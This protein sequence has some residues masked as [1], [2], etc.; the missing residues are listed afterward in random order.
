MPSGDERLPDLTGRVIGILD[1]ASGLAHMATETL[2]GCGAYAVPLR[3]AR[4][5]ESAIR[6]LSVDALI[7]QGDHP[8]CEHIVT[9][10]AQHRI[11]AVVFDLGTLDDRRRRLLVERGARIVTTAA[12]SALCAAV[13]HGVGGD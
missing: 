13:V 9:V 3:D 7:V 10:A 8:D 6:V 4:L 5:A 2:R 12:P 11:P 1:P